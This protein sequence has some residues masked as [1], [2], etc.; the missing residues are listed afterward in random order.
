MNEYSTRTVLHCDLNNFYASVECLDNPE[1]KDKAVV[2]T[3][4]ADARHGVVLAKNQI[5]KQA[6]IK[7]GMV[8]WEAREKVK[9][10][11]AITANFNKYIKYSR[12]VREIYARY[13]DLIE[14]FGIDESWLDV[15][16]SKKLF[17]DGETIAN[18]IRETIKKEIGL[19]VSIGVSFNKIFAKLGSDLKKPDAVTVITQHNF[20][21]KI[22]PLPAS[23]LLYVG[24][25]TNEKLGRIGINTIGDLANANESIL[26]KLLGKWGTYLKIFAQG[27]DATPV[28]KLGEETLIKSVGNS[29]TAARDLNTSLDVSLIFSVLADS[30]AARLREQNLKASVVSIWVRDNKLKSFSYQ[31]R[32]SKPSF[33]SNE[34]LVKAKELFK[35]HKFNEPI[36]S[37]GLNASELCVASENEVSQL[38]FFTNEKFREKSEKV[39]TAVDKIRKKYGHNSIVTSNLLLDEELTLFNPKEE[40]TIHPYSFF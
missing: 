17:G 4:D 14:N 24:K 9:E 19:T 13:T 33:L 7:T 32:L 2:V 40:N 36:R 35:K 30:V 39:E 21:E 31:G 5:A 12:R 38:D 8:I 34:F 20:K 27:Y 10:L 25:K 26:N 1:I 23:E 15:T 29:T 16:H 6:G 22:W 18:K 37:L 3:G 11:V 28:T